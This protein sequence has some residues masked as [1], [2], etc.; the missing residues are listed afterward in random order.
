VSELVSRGQLSVDAGEALAKLREYRLADPHHWVLDVLRAAVLSKATAVTVRTDADDVEIELDGAPFPREALAEIFGHALQAGKSDEAARFRLLALGVTGALAMRP[1]WVTVHG[2]GVVLRVRPPDKLALEPG[3]DAP[4]TRV[5]SRD[6]TSWRVVKR[7]FTRSPEAEV[8]ADRARFFPAA[9]TVN[10]E[11]IDG[12]PAWEGALATRTVR[13]GSLE[14]VGAVL[15]EPLPVSVLEIDVH[16]VTVTRRTVDLPALQIVAWARDDGLR[17][18]ASGS[19]IV[20]D[21]ADT[22]RLFAHLEG[23]ADELLAEVAGD[24]RARA[25]LTQAALRTAKR[26]RPK[27]R[28]CSAR[29]RAILDEARLLP[30]PSGEW[31]SIAE[32]RAEVEQGRAIR[33]ASRRYPA[34][35]YRAP[36][37]YLDR[38]GS[39]LR[40]LLPGKTVDIGEDVERRL[41]FEER[42]KR[43]EAQPVETLVLPALRRWLGRATVHGDGVR[44]LV[45]VPASAHA[46]TARLL[47]GGRVLEQRELPVLAPLRVHAVVDADFEANATWDGVTGDL[48]PV[49]ALIREGAALAIESALGDGEPP[50]EHARDLAVSLVEHGQAIADLPPVLRAAPIWELAGGGWTSLDAIVEW[51][52]CRYVTRSWNHPAL[53]G[54]PIVVLGE[55]ERA[56]LAALPGHED[57]GP[58]L[59]GEL[60]IRRRLAG[61]R[62]A[63][64]LGECWARLP[65]EGEGIRGEIG[66][67]M[68]TTRKRTLALELLREGV[69]LHVGT[70]PAR[71]GNADAIVDAPALQPNADWTGVARD[72]VYERILAGVRDAERRL[73]GMLVERHGAKDPARLPDG[74]RDALF[75]FAERELAA[76]EGRELDELARRVYEAKL[77]CGLDGPLSLAEVARSAGAEGGAWLIDPVMSRPPAPAGMVVVVADAATRKLLQS[78]LMRPGRDAARELELR[79]RL[80]DFLA[81]PAR[82][83]RLGDDVLKVPFAGRHFA[84]ELGHAPG[85][86]PELRLTALYQGR[87]LCRETRAARVSLEAVIEVERAGGDPLERVLPPIVARE[88]GT[89]QKGA[90][91]KLVDVAIADPKRSS[92]RAFVLEAIE[93]GLDDKLGARQAERLRSATIFPVVA[94]ADVAAND[95]RFRPRL[96]Y[97]T[98]PFETTLASGEPV[99]LAADPAVRAALAAFGGAV[100]VGDELTD[101]IR[102]RRAWD[103]R[104]AEPVVPDG[105][106][107]GPSRAFQKGDVAGVVAIGSFGSVAFFVKEHRICAQPLLPTGVTAAVSCDRL[108]LGPKRDS[109]VEDVVFRGIVAEVEAQAIALLADEAAR[110]PGLLHAARLAPIAGWL[111]WRKHRDHP[112]LGVPFLLATDGAP[113]SVR[114]LLAE[115]ARAGGLPYASIR[116]SL[117][118]A[119]RRVLRPRPGE[120]EALAAAGVRLKD[121]TEVVERAEELRLR[122]ILTTLAVP[123]STAW[124]EPVTGDGIV[125]EA[126]IVTSAPSEVLELELVVLGRLVERLTL[127]HPIGGRA[128]VT[129]PELVLLDDLKVKR[130]SVVRVREAAHAALDRLAL[131]FVERGRA[132]PGWG[133][134]ALAAARAW[135]DRIEALPLFVDREGG[136][137]APAALRAGAAVVIDDGLAPPPGSATPIVVVGPAERALLEALEIPCRDLSEEARAV[138]ERERRRLSERRFA[139]DALV[140]LAVDEHGWSGELALPARLDAGGAILLA[141]GGVAVEPFRIADLGVAGVLDHEAL[142]VDDR[143]SRALLGAEQTAFVSDRV[144]ALFAELAG[145]LPEKRRPVAAAYALRYLVH[146]GVSDASHL[147]RLAGVVDRL[148]RAKIFETSDGRWVD[149]RSIADRLLRGGEVP[150]LDDSLSPDAAAGDVVLKGGPWIAELGAVLGG[151]GL[152]RLQ[153]RKEWRAFQAEADP[154]AGTPLHAGLLRLR[155]EAN[156]LRADA[157]GVLDPGELVAVRV[158]RGDGRVP[159]DYDTARGIAFVDPEHAAV[160]HALECADRPDLVYVLLAAIYGA[161]NRALDRVTDRDEARLAGSLLSHLATNPGLLSI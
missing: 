88:I 54:R 113:L 153:S 157:L 130:D 48:A 82:E 127:P 56:L 64:R 123:D 114:E 46:S 15:E 92:A 26:A 91:G 42:R 134:Y 45:G 43:F 94:G 65:L 57:V 60:E 69:S 98:T 16:G 71:Y 99:V 10:G 148:A 108:T 102:A 142:P 75:A 27:R 104:A 25:A 107:H 139:G 136:R 146:A 70:S 140:R 121:V 141:R 125:G 72:A 68:E 47:K 33:I 89:A 11:R 135:K 126:A 49:L 155:R 31:C 17:R 22:M 13:A 76:A 39:E 21:D 106:V 161:V 152:R 7:A 100:D 63:A 23:C 110:L 1:R 154:D 87:F 8:I 40:A 67:P 80:A 129:A 96:C 133:A 109:I 35:L 19:D 159:I 18:N 138:A 59:A 74:V 143:W 85:G 149:L 145:E 66:V 120:L 116:G 20:D 62:R 44:V 3:D 124:R 156:L 2:S 30:G 101:E 158:R 24:E 111:L 147:D 150:L 79:Q 32:L 61:P 34:E 29:A 95:L 122:P 4:G 132:E 77:L 51:D 37:V 38:P 12:R 105:G 117:L 131:R 36:V 128:R 86:E 55:S 53:D 93:R 119:G 103:E 90:V 9:L 81:S 14:L 78:V 97:V 5:H 73:I 58:R 41:R 151:K 50:R 112:L 83:A 115:E 137:V 144:A 28:P 52:S 6:R 160:R 118:D 84:G